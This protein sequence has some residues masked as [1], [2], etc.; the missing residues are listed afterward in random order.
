MLCHVR[1][2]NIQF[3]SN[4]NPIQDIPISIPIPK[5][6]Y[7]PLLLRTTAYFNTTTFFIHSSLPLNSL[8]L[9]TLPFPSPSLPIPPQAHDTT[10]TTRKNNPLT[11]PPPPNQPH[12]LHLDTSPPS[13]PLL[14]ISIS[15]PLLLRPSPLFST[16]TSMR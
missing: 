8:I 5:S 13:L 1:I 14:L 10:K 6:L 16:R 2:R 7:F 3:N 12:N 15:H 4:S 11:P 9:K